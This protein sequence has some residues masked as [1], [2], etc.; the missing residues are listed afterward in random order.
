MATAIEQLACRAFP[1]LHES[2]IHEGLGKAFVNSIRK[3]SLKWLLLN[4]RQEDTQ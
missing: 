3:Q 1:A 2:Y 4:G